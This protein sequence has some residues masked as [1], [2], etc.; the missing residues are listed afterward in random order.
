MTFVD[1]VRLHDLVVP[2]SDAE[3]GCDQ[4]DGAVEIDAR[5]GFWQ[6]QVVSD[7]LNC[8]DVSGV[9]TSVASRVLFNM[10]LRMVLDV[11]VMLVSL[12]VSA[13]R[14]A[15][16]IDW[17]LGLHFRWAVNCMSGAAVLFN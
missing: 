11:M 5:V 1:G 16:R 6:L 7:A 12:N 9:T 3:A 15:V 10:A 17:C 2:G 13:G 14:W 4:T 8:L